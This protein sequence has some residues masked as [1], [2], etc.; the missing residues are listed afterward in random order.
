MSKFDKC[1]I[2]G[3][4]NMDFIVITFRNRPFIDGKCYPAMCFGCAH[5][6]KDYVLEYDKDGNVAEQHGPFFDHK[7]LQTGEE[8]FDAGSTETLLEARRCVRGVNK[9]LKAIGKVGLKKLGKFSLPKYDF[10]MKDDDEEQDQPKK[11]RKKRTP[12]KVASEEA[13]KK[14]AAPKKKTA[15]KKKKATYKKKP[16]SS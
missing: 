5:V 3:Q 2:C 15:K 4:E 13:P 12:K 10:E 7:H 8:L 6:P 16:K 9:K 1:P 14:K 11:T